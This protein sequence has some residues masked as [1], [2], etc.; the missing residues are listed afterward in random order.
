MPFRVRI[1]SDGRPC[2]PA[3][4]QLGVHALAFSVLSSLAN[5]YRP[6]DSN[7]ERF[8]PNW[9]TSTANPLQAGECIL[10]KPSV[11]IVP[12]V[13]S[14]YII[15][16]ASRHRASNITPCPFPTALLYDCTQFYLT[17]RTKSRQLGLSPKTQN[18]ELHLV[19]SGNTESSYHL[20]IS[21]TR[22]VR[23]RPI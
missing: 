2:P 8:Q 20:G 5:A 15:D 1:V 14:S 10:L 4:L 12:T 23:R 7:R 11:G 6:S 18:D 17:S 16:N 9:L 19:V 21:T 3:S 13:F 22:F